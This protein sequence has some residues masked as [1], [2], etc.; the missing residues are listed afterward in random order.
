MLVA[1]AL[2]LGACSSGG[3]ADE[4][5]AEGGGTETCSGSAIPAGELQLPE[6]FP[7]PDGMT[8][9][10]SDKEGPSGV[11]DGYF[12]GDLKDAH[13]EWKAA[14]GD[15]NWTV[16]SDELEEHDSEVNYKSAD[17]SSTGQVALREECEESG[18]TAVHITDRPA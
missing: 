16:L 7:T 11:A 4:G 2:A 5:E 10:E 6:G 1:L 17:G 14:F 15:A 13:D 8:I 18:R 12:E 9:T 3:K